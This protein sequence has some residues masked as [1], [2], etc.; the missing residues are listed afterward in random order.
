MRMA[1]GSAS[2]EKSVVASSR[3]GRDRSLDPLAIDV[4]DVALPLLELI[5]LGRVDVET[6]DVEALFGE[7]EGE[8]EA[9]VAEADDA[10]K[11]GTIIDFGRER[12]CVINH[13]Y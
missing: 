3:A 11:G 6:D 1:S 13:T 12:L 8:R 7:C 5:D 10:D 4:F 2:R 9:D